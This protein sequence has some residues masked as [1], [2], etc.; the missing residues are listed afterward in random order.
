M[1]ATDN[2]KNIPPEDGKLPAAGMGNASNPPLKEDQLEPAHSNQ[3]IDE[4]G[5]KYLREVAPI[6]DYPD[7]QDEQDMERTINKEKSKDQ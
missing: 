5:E 6:E 4:R 1:S 7:A 2:N 3:L